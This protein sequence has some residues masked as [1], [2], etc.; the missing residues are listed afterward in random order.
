MALVNAAVDMLIIALLA[1]YAW[2]DIQTL[3]VSVALIVLIAPLP[4]GKYNGMV[5]YFIINKAVAEYRLPIHQVFIPAIVMRFYYT[6]R[7][8][9]TT[10]RDVSISP[11]SFYHF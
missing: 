3:P 2:P 4:F 1:A 10:L 9:S 8:C 7:H 6:H 5:T 11:S